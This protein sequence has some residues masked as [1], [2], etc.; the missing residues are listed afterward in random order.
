MT[1]PGGRVRVVVVEDSLVQR[2]HLV[3]TLVAEG[4]ITVVGEATGAREAAALVER[5]RPD[6]VT[7]DLEIPEG[8][9]LAAVEQ[10]MAFAPTPIL[11]LSGK[12]AGR[13]SH[14]AVAALVAGALDAVPKPARW[15]PE[16]ESDLRRRVRLLGRTPV[17]R[18]PRGRLAPVASAPQQ[19]AASPARTAA[20][21][22]VAVVGIAASS[23][24]PQALATVLEG[25]AGRA[26]AVLV[27]QHLHPD[28]LAGFVTWMARVCPLPVATAVAGA[29]LRPG[30]VHVGPVGVHL[31]VDASGRRIA[32]DPS[33][34]RLHCPSAD[35]LF[36]S[37]ARSLGPAGVGVVLTGMGDDGAAGLRALR[38]AGGRT[39]VQDESTSAVYGMPRAA[40]AAG[41]ATEV[42]PLDAVAGA[43]QRAVRG[44]RR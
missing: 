3:A 20:P 10:I 14:A 41:A 27:V 21:G 8:G 6:V 23:G 31:K 32:L 29:T 30:T 22:G 43:V 15:T 39:I 33:P 19:T 13:E 42:L 11:I 5:L 1:A 38:Q 37:M 28:F 34:V 18:H 17:I 24:G 2:S 25:F 26:A 35:E 9:G 12:I 40:F 4:D 16:A 44:V 36:S 7:L